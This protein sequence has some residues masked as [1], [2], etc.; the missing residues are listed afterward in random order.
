MSWRDVS[1][2]I[3]VEWLVCRMERPH[4]SLV[5]VLAVVAVSVYNGSC[6]KNIPVHERQISNIKYTTVEL[7]RSA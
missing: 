6:T 1:V 3:G 2:T 7:Q 5:G 4:V